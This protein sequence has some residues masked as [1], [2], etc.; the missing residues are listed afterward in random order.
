LWKIKKLI[1]TKRSEEKIKLRPAKVRNPKNLNS[2]FSHELN[3]CSSPRRK[4]YNPP[5]YFLEEFEERS[6]LQ[7]DGLNQ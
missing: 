2:G 3:F 1:K 6:N 4:S 5:S 7:R